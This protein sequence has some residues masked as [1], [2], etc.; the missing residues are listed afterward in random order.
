MK[1]EIKGA[2][3]MEKPFKTETIQISDYMKYRTIMCIFFL[4]ISFI[5]MFISKVIDNMTVLFSAIVIISILTIFLVFVMNTVFKSKF[6]NTAL[7]NYYSD[8]IDIHINNTSYIIKYDN[9]ININYFPKFAKQTKGQTYINRYELI[10][11]DK[12]LD[13]FKL[14]TPFDKYYSDLKY[15][16]L[17][18]IMYYCRQFMPKKNTELAKIET[19]S[20]YD[21]TNDYSYN[22][23]LWDEDTASLDSFIPEQCYCIKDYIFICHKDTLEIRSIDNK[24]LYTADWKKL[25]KIYV[26]EKYAKRASDGKSVVFRILFNDYRYK[27]FTISVHQ[28]SETLIFN[29]SDDISVFQML[30]KH[31]VYFK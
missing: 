28:N 2:K 21:E 5:I 18:N 25:Q 4:F 10:I 30:N 6:N 29:N 22:A 16:G 24:T 31:I 14:S 19:P 9:I 12:D 23:I 1:S 3:H 11:K 27:D 20:G 17:Y 13:N 8:Y 26:F 7:M 15:S